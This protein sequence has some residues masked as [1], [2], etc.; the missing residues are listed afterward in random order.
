MLGNY[1]KVKSFRL[2]QVQDQQLSE[3]LDLLQ[4]APGPFQERIVLMIESVHKTLSQGS[5]LKAKRPAR[6]KRQPEP[7]PEPE[8]EAEPIPEVEA[9][10]EPAQRTEPPVKTEDAEY[11]KY[12]R[13]QFSQVIETSPDDYIV[14]PCRDEW[15]H[16]KDFCPG[17]H[18]ANPK[19]YLNCQAS[20]QKDPYGELFITQKAKPGRS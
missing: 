8:L 10:P 6:I 19:M 20:R 4:I 11:L 1:G 3:I 2:K 18:N 7:E 9:E 5:Q 12:E 16:P 15:V 14:C 17:C 13:D